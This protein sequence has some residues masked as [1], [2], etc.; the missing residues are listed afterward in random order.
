[1]L[2]RPRDNGALNGEFVR[3]VFNL[4]GT[5][6]QTQGDIDTLLANGGIRFGLHIQSLEIGE[7]GRDYSEALISTSVVIDDQCVGG[8]CVSTVPEPTSMLLLGTGLL[9][10]ARA[11]RRGK[12][13]SISC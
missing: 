13:S 9:A 2:L 8:T 6:T 4:L 3:L 7:N 5:P 12:T 1:M 11:A 10:A